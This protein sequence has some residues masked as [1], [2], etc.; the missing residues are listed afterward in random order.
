MPSLRAFSKNQEI[1]KKIRSCLRH[2]FPYALSACPLLRLCPRPPT[3]DFFLRS[4][5]HAGPSY[6]LCPRRRL[7]MG[8]ARSAGAPGGPPRHPPRS[9]GAP[10]GPPRHSPTGASGGLPRSAGASGGPPCPHRRV[11]WAATLCRCPRRAAM[12]CPHRRVWWAAT[13]CRR[14]RRTATPCPHRRVR[15]AASVG[16]LALPVPPASRHGEKRPLACVSTPA[17]YF[18][19]HG[20]IVTA[21]ERAARVKAAQD[22]Y[23]VGEA[24]GWTPAVPAER[25]QTVAYFAVT[26]SKGHLDSARTAVGA[27]ELFCQEEG[28]PPW[29]ADWVRVYLFFKLYAPFTTPKRAT[30]IEGRRPWLCWPPPASPLASPLPAPL[31]APPPAQPPLRASAGGQHS[32]GARGR[33][34]QGKRVPRHSKPNLESL[35]RAPRMR[36]TPGYWLRPEMPLLGS[37]AS[38]FARCASGHREKA[39]NT[40]RPESSGRSM[41]SPP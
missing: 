26:Y 17:D 24:R 22:L 41:F 28:L 18:V 29:P 15:W 9:A 13:L 10:G 36:A 27:W 34:T 5:Q 12:P 16:S 3:R 14:P 19:Q 31:P 40:E 11:R 7:P 6:T 38:G 2:V 35:F 21:T 4:F 39:L 8:G 37:G 23:M 25:N 30:T 33:G 32:R 1:I 20:H